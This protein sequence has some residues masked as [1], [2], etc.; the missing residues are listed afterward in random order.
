[1]AMDTQGILSAADLEPHFLENDN[2]KNLT[3]MSNVPELCQTEPCILGVDE[4][5]RGPVLGLFCFG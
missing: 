4:A 2:S 3:L 5:G 1:M